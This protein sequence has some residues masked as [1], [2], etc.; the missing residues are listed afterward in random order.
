MIDGYV[1]RGL[2]ALQR[3]LEPHIDTPSDV[4]VSLRL[5]FSCVPSP[6]LSS[7]K[8]TALSCSSPLKLRTGYYRSWDL[9]LVIFTSNEY[10][11]RTSYPLLP[12]N[13]EI[14]FS[15]RRLRCDSHQ[16]E[17]K[18]TTTTPSGNGPLWP[19]ST[20]DPSY[21][22]FPSKTTNNKNDDND[23]K[24][25]FL[26]FRV[27]PRFFGYCWPFFPALEK[28]FP[29]FFIRVLPKRARCS[30]QAHLLGQE[31]W[32]RRDSSLFNSPKKPLL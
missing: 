12:T 17:K 5:G 1:G 24:N 20:R 25:C 31:G 10:A 9:M 2:Y 27:G 23:N 6:A 32:C 3:N 21:P 15:C 29:L 13:P 14:A 7:R 16:Q 8:P 18:Q 22:F 11:Q 28:L 4:V 26:F 30:T 19:A